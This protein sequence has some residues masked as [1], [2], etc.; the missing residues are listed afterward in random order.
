LNDELLQFY[1]RELAFFRRMSGEFAEANPKI[2]GRLRISAETCDDPHVERMIEAFALLNAR[3][4]QKLDD[5]FPEL[6]DALLG[7]L[8]PHYL[9]PV[10]SMAIV[11]LHADP[12][13]TPP[14]GYTVSTGSELETEPIDGEPCRFRTCYETTLFPIEVESARLAGRPLPAPPTPHSSAA[15]AVLRIGLTCLAEEATFADVEAD[16]LRFFL[17]GQAHHT[18]PL[19]ELIFNN[20]I[21]VAVAESPTDPEPLVLPAS[22]LRTVGFGRDEGMLPYDARSPLGYRLL[23]E[24][25]TFPEKF[26]F[27]ELTGLEQGRSRRTWRE[28]EL[29][30]YFDQSKIDLERNVSEDTLQLGCTPVVNLFSQRAEPIQ[31]TPTQNE[32]P[33]IPDAR[34]QKAM[35]IYSIDAVTA[36]SAY[37]EETPYF[38][39]YAIRHEADAGGNEAYWYATRRP[40]VPEAGEV[41]EGTDMELSLVDL[42]FRPLA[43]ADWVVDAR[44]TCLNRDL[45]N[46]LPFGGDQ[47]RLYLTGGEGA[48]SRVQ[49]LTP[50]TP[51]R[52]P[53]RGYAGLW[54]L[55]SHLSL[56]HLSIVDGD[57]GGHAM[58]EMLRLYDFV[59]NAE[60]RDLIDSVLAVSSR[61]IAGR[62]VGGGLGGVARGVKINVLFRPEGY[63]E[64]GLYLFGRVLEHFFGL[65][66]SINSFTKLTATVRGREELLLDSA[67][68]AADKVLV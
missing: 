61:R 26:L 21:E 43:N 28:M 34:R 53:P 41:D 30:I 11:K 14:A 32:Y 47:P 35:E 64:K 54:R 19:Y 56:N 60:T 45:P 46:R 9:A 39:F 18:L 55:I 27:F 36:I 66:C 40:G 67:P 65:M 1:N 8:Y 7:T 15:V 20:A 10:P 5:D 22:C 38:P 31:L 23:T 42:K 57:E 59:E 17:R 3:I 4:R 29:Y 6:T 51:T 33:I 58:R 68:R 52:R 49:C 44:T 16:A 24:Y 37:G 2:A 13:Q 50:P 63:S 25:F 48:V 62:V 12:E